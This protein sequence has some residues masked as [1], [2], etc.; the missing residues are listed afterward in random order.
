MT[1]D[2]HVAFNVALAIAFIG[3]LDP[4][5][6]LLEKVFPARKAA[7]T[8]MR[9]VISTPPRSTRPRWR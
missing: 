2:F 8:P 7:P 9:R 4:L 1:A 6:K 3:L 5:A